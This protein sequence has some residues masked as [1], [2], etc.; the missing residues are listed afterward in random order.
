MLANGQQKAFTV[1]RK[2][3]DRRAE[4]SKEAKESSLAVG[5]VDDR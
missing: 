5:D 3:L 1:R 4:C 2:L